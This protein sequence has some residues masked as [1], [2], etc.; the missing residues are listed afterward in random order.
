[1]TYYIVAFALALLAICAFFEIRRSIR[2][3]RDRSNFRPL[4]GVTDPA[5]GRTL[6]VPHDEFD[7]LPL[8]KRPPNIGGIGNPPY[9]GPNY[10]EAEELA[11]EL[12][13]LPHY[14]AG[15]AHDP[16]RPNTLFPVRLQDQ[17]F[18]DKEDES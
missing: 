4:I 8:A 5:T 16:Q 10:V 11:E 6:L 1:M 2:S 7:D 13:D 17:P 14:Y 18:F 9:M 12:H 3:S 15:D